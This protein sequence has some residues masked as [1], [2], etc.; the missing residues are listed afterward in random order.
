MFFA[1]SVPT[2]GAAAAAESLASAGHSAAMNFRVGT[3]ITL[4]EASADIQQTVRAAQGQA[5]AAATSP[6]LTGATVPSGTAAAA[7]AG[8]TSPTLN[9]AAPASA[10]TSAGGMTAPTISAACVQQQQQLLQQQQQQA[11]SGVLSSILARQ[12]HATKLAE[13]AAAEYNRAVLDLEQA[14]AVQLQQQQQQQVQAAM[15]MSP[16]DVAIVQAQML[17]Q[18]MRLQGGMMPGA[19]T[20]MPNTSLM[21]LQAQ[22]AQLQYQ[23][24]Q[25]LLQEAQT[26]EAL[27]QAKVSAGAAAAAPAPTAQQPQASANATSVVE[28]TKLSAAAAPGTT[29]TDSENAGTKT[30]TNEGPIKT[31][32][33]EDLDAAE[34]VLSLMSGGV[35]RSSLGPGTAT[36]ASTKGQEQSSHSQSTAP[37]TFVPSAQMLLQAATSESSPPN[38]ETFTSQKRKQARRRST[39][40]S[41]SSEAS[42]D[43]FA[44]SDES[45]GKKQK[46]TRSKKKPG[47]P[48]RPLSAYNIFFSEERA[49]IIKS[50]EEEMGADEALDEGGDEEDPGTAPTRDD[51]AS[52]PLKKRRLS[53]E[54]TGRSSACSSPTLSG[55][56]VGAVAGQKAQQILLDR[57]VNPAGPGRSKRLHRRT[58]GRI[59]FQDLARLI[60]QRWK[61]LPADRMDEYKR[62][63]EIDTKR[64]KED[65]VVWNAQQKELREK[66]QQQQQN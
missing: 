43:Y 57:R 28:Q 29:T 47:Q 19:M 2:T 16:Y 50:M 49:R 54:S 63:A 33:K 61:T 4:A 6:T 56:E 5:T 7:A 59:G 41:N 24:Q 58:H 14:T 9:P 40:E 27:G 62:L 13:L 17:G 66:E 46:K 3:P 60:G 1:P 8:Y 65:M 48:R 11:Q 18:Q 42:G 10:L 44:A 64:Y 21:G 12:S 45:G 39:T 38:E 52:G 23:Q 51:S 36:T 32:A 26:I 15:A 22:Q 35:R 31:S 53:L 55:N 20:M 25:L 37:S 30:R 34:A